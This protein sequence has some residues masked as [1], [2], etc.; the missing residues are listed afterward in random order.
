MWEESPLPFVIDVALQGELRVRSTRT[1]RTDSLLPS[2]ARAGHAVAVV[3]ALAAVAACGPAELEVDDERPDLHLLSTKADELPAWLHR[4]S[5]RLLC[6]GAINGRFAGR[7]SAHLY[8]L[9]G[10]AG[11]EMTLR[12]AGSYAWQR[13]AALA[14]YDAGT[15]VLV[16]L[17]RNP[18]AAEV[19]MTQD[20]LEDREYLLSVYSLAWE[21]DGAYSVIAECRRETRRQ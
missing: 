6:G 11:V 3:V 12:F 7:N 16:Q 15:G 2:L 4:K 9:A 8:P 1:H 13:G 10:E 20:R 17:L 5:D 19:T 21:A 18:W 14:L